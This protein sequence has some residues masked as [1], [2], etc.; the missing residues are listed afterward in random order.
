[1]VILDHGDHLYSIYGYA[2]D[3]AVEPGQVVQGGD[4]IA[5]VGATGPVERPSLYFE[6]RDHGTPRDPGQYIAAL[7]HR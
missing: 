7:A 5:S 3:I 4:E 1:M 2:S 6:I